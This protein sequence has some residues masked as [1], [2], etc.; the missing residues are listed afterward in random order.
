MKITNKG[1]IPLALGV[2]LLHD[3][4][5]YQNDPC[6]ISATTLMKPLRAYILAKRVERQDTEIDLEEYISRALGHSLHDSI[7]RVWKNDKARNR[8]LKLLG[9]PDEVI[10]K[11]LINPTPED[12]KRVPDCIPIYLEQRHTRMMGKYRIGGKYDMVADGVLHDNKSTTA[13]AWLF[14][15]KDEDYQL[16][17]SIYR[18]LAPEVITEDIIR[19]NF[20]F[21][22][23]QKMQAK[24]NPAYPQ[25]RAEHRDIPLTDI[26]STENWI[27]NKIAMIEKYKDAPD[28][29]IPECT[30]TELWM[31]EPVFKYYA[32]ATKTA[33][34]SS[35]N[36][37]DRFEA[38]QYWTVEKGGKGTVIEVVAKPKRC[39]YCDAAP[40]CEQRLKYL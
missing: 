16:Q 27:K 8:S 31:S 17:G 36:F 32:D 29:E 24:T 22:D 4:Y 14:G 21:T 3:E 23:W 18:W 38:H 30:P 20:I 2:W 37:N 9:I 34:R 6:Y 26:R 10:A 12:L 40:V 25:K 28:A 15:G 35:R 11:V 1:N 39:E 19:I 33:G 7:E 13:Y 5:D